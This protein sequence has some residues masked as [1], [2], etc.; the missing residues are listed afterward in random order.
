MPAE[1]DRGFATRAIHGQA[2]PEIAQDVP[3]VPIYQ[4]STFRFDTSDAYAETIAFRRPGYTY[5]RGYGNPTLL[6]FERLMADLEGT[7]SAIT[8]ASG[9]AAIHTLATTVAAGGDTIVA[10]SEL[11]GGTYSLFAHVLPRYG[12]DVRFVD[13]HDHD[14]VAA[15]L[16]DA[17]LLYLETI[18]NPNVTVSDLEALGRIAAATGVPSA[19]DNTFASP[20]LCQPLSLGADLV[21]ESATKWLGGHSDVIAGVVAGSA[22]RIRAIRSVAVDTGG[23]IAPLSAFLVLRGMLT[24]HVRMDRH[25]ESA[26]AVARHLEPHP[27]LHSVTYP[28]LPSHPQHEVAKDRET[29]GPSVPDERLV[30]SPSGGLSGA[31]FS[32]EAPA[33]GRLSLD[34]LSVRLKWVNRYGGGVMHRPGAFREL[35]WVM[36]RSRVY[37][38]WEKLRYFRAEAFS[39]AHLY[40]DLAAGDLFAEIPALDVPVYFVHGRHDHQ[41]PMAVARAYHDALDASHK[42]FVV[43]DDG[44]SNVLDLEGCLWGPVFKPFRTAEGFAKLRVEG[45][46]IVWS[47]QANIAPETLYLMCLGRKLPRRPRRRAAPRSGR[48][49]GWPCRRGAPSPPRRA[50]AASRR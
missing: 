41:V 38:T 24:L 44:L 31:V 2:S 16:P 42:E 40:D 28:G 22:A 8:F 17:K 6:A 29:C 4:A 3:S 14:A 10:S 50:R 18:A 48:P 37:T 5:T 35:A 19:V 45:G 9:M 36:A 20:Y 25:S 39:L 11:Y 30:T 7:A 12:I 23:I 1:R 46:T 49:R 21:V 43:F 15:A 33:A 32:L 27:E 47:D 34:D 13:P 26:L